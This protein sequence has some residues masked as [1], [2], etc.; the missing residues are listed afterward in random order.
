[1]RADVCGISAPQTFPSG[2]GAARRRQ[3]RAVRRTDAEKSQANSYTLKAK[4]P[5]LLLLEKVA[6]RPDVEGTPCGI[7]VG[8]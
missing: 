8:Q 1:M 3:M 4:A 7:A 6:R 2:E 5:S